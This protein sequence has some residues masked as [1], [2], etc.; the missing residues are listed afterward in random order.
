MS[1]AWL[2]W[3][4]KAGTGKPYAKHVTGGAK[5]SR[6]GWLGRLAEGS[7]NTIH[8][9]GAV[10]GWPTH[11]HEKTI[12]FVVLKERRRGS[13]P[14]K[15]DKEFVRFVFAQCGNTFQKGFDLRHRLRPNP[16]PSLIAEKNAGPK[17]IGV[18]LTANGSLFWRKFGK[19]AQPDFV[20]QFELFRVSSGIRWRS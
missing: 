16:H 9:Q 10:A 5:V 15:Y 17:E 13:F 14:G 7:R 12:G 19:V 3:C 4:A 1:A 20:F 6:V 11:T 18:H 8:I 2:P